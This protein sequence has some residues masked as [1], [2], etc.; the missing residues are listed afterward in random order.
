MNMNRIG[1]IAKNRNDGARDLLR[2]LAAFLARE[3]KVTSLL[4]QASRFIDLRSALTRETTERKGPLVD[5]LEQEQK[6][7]ARERKELEATRLQ[8][9]KLPE[10]VIIYP[11]K[12]VDEPTGN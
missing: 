8:E 1:V 12:W 9:P 10:K 5:V 11:V 6:V 4:E 7:L 3:K 2:G